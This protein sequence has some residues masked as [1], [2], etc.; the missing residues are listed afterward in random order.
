[1]S[2]LRIY[3]QP[4]RWHIFGLSPHKLQ[5]QAVKQ[6]NLGVFREGSLCSEGRLFQTCGLPVNWPPPVHIT[7]V[8]WQKENPFREGAHLVYKSHRGSG[9]LYLFTFG[10]KNNLAKCGCIITSFSPATLNWNYQKV[11][12]N[13]LDIVFNHTTFFPKYNHFSLTKDCW[14]SRLGDTRFIEQ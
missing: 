1:M 5:T 14:R 3:R 7:V 8:L 11:K 10:K 9:L 12:Y 13:L 6:A 4:Y 2:G